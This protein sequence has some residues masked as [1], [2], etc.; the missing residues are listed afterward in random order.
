MATNIVNDNTSIDIDIKLNDEQR[1]RLYDMLLKHDINISGHHN[2][3][4]ALNRMYLKTL[5][6]TVEQQVK[7]Y[8]DGSDTVFLTECD[9]TRL[10]S[11]SFT[12][13][14]GA[15]VS[16]SKNNPNVIVVST[17][18]NRLELTYTVDN[19]NNLIHISESVFLDSEFIISRDAIA[20]FK[21]KQIIPQTSEYEAYFTDLK[22][23]IDFIKLDNRLLF[24]PEVN[25]DDAVFGLRYI[26]DS[27]E[28]PVLTLLC[29]YTLNEKIYL[30]HT[31]IFDLNDNTL[32]LDKLGSIANHK[33][34]KA[35]DNINGYITLDETWNSNVRNFDYDFYMFNGQIIYKHRAYDGITDKY[36]LCLYNC[37]DVIIYGVDFE[38]YFSTDYN[39]DDGAV[40]LNT[41]VRTSHSSV[42]INN[43][44][45][46]NILENT[47]E[48][49]APLT[50][51]SAYNFDIPNSVTPST[52]IDSGLRGIVP[53]FRF[54]AYD[55]DGKTLCN[56]YDYSYSSGDT[57][58]FGTNGTL[59]IS[60]KAS[61]EIGSSIDISKNRTFAT[62]NYYD[63]TIILD[64]KMFTSTTL[65]GVTTTTPKVAKVV[66]TCLTGFDS[67]CYP[68]A[69][70][71]GRY[72]IPIG[73]SLT[74]NFGTYN[75]SYF[76]SLGVPFEV[77]Y[78]NAT[79]IYG[80]RKCLNNVT[81]TD[82]DLDSYGDFDGHFTNL[83]T[84]TSNVN[85]HN[86]F[87]KALNTCYPTVW[88][89]LLSRPNS[90]V[91]TQGNIYS[92]D[93]FST[94]SYHDIGAESNWVISEGT[95]R[96]NNAGSGMT[97]STCNILLIN[98]EVHSVRDGLTGLNESMYVYPGNMRGVSNARVPKHAI[99]GGFY[100][101]AGHGGVYTTGSA[102]FTHTSDEYTNG[103]R[104]YHYSSGY[105]SS[106][107][108][109]TNIIFRDAA[110]GRLV[111]KDETHYSGASGSGYW[112]Y[113]S[114][115]YFDNCTLG[116]LRDYNNQSNVNAVFNVTGTICIGEL[117]KC[118]ILNPTVVYD[119]NDYYITT[120]YNHNNKIAPP[121]PIS[122]I[123]LNHKYASRMIYT[124]PQYLTTVMHSKT[125][126]SASLSSVDDVTAPITAE[127]KFDGH[128]F[129]PYTHNTPLFD[130]IVYRAD[131]LNNENP[132]YVV[133]SESLEDAYVESTP[134]L[135]EHY[136]LNTIT[137]NG[138][139]VGDKIVFQHRI[140]SD[141]ADET[142]YF[143]PIIKLF[144]A[145]GTVISHDI[146]L[147][148]AIDYLIK[149][150]KNGVVNIHNAGD[151]KQGV[152]NPEFGRYIKTVYMD[153][154]T[155]SYVDL[156]TGEQY[157]ITV[158]TRSTGFISNCK[159]SGPLAFRNDY[160]SRQYIGK[161]NKYGTTT[162]NATNDFNKLCISNPD[163]VISR[164]PNSALDS[165]V[166]TNE[167][168][169]QRLPHWSFFN[170]M[171]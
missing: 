102:T 141:D 37:N 156:E 34:Y 114:Y 93:C 3:E 115:S 10:I 63:G 121:S 110:F 104:E 41:A 81:L 169:R 131:D 136:E 160:L 139:H 149:F 90:I 13:S 28:F 51:H 5:F 116:L 99:V 152:T 9:L 66:F 58:L 145:N 142:I 138:L 105:T 129:A 77:R 101:S 44:T 74:I 87:S 45:F 91:M 120:K 40:T 137:V 12:T 43:C 72:P 48:T 168:Y 19:D 47:T 67:K 158:P 134:T 170:D 124:I 83:T 31:I 15:L 95:L 153:A 76:D 78:K 127:I 64:N 69:T 36:G 96:D 123:T 46:N 68:R 39:I 71:S 128:L 100:S 126:A 157:P 17:A 54:T 42:W 133:Q 27:T 33:N 140:S 61:T 88:Y 108:R 132:I 35:F 60:S 151:Y 111:A 117:D 118:Y 80:N 16:I 59:Q 24:A 167:N 18:S 106:F 73:Q 166:V 164:K 23:A 38:S 122:M 55:S 94:A 22:S 97:V 92:R 113:G 135:S 56:G 7:I 161:N 109:P 146:S 147:W 112:G 143:K 148:Q 150:P 159:L 89:N 65:D 14:S 144:N 8:V 79:T 84:Y 162:M 165:I 155:F 163:Q 70:E 75:N 86:V 6:D 4:E 171:K 2:L 82:I 50:V 29:D 125:A 20:T 57:S 30:D 21:P 11:L 85:M 107:V 119:Y 62:I 1:V 52:V 25:H 98:L 154:T 49:S 53:F 130:V 26:G 32:I 103:V